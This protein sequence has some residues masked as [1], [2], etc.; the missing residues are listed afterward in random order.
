MEE[1]S[2]GRVPKERRVAKRRG[3]NGRLKSLVKTDVVLF[4]FLFLV[5]LVSSDRFGLLKGASARGTWRVVGMRLNDEFG[6]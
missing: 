5:S 1:R 2:V 6:S 4:L 3:T